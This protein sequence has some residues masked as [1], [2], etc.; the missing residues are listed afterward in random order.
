MIETNFIQCFMK[1]AVSV[2]KDAP[3]CKIGQKA[4]SFN[5]IKTKEK[6]REK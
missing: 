6:G 3:N 2:L 5:G 1:W 4:G